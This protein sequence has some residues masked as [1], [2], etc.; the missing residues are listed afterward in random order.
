M[1]L[2]GKW[3]LQ[4]RIASYFGGCCL[5]RKPVHVLDHVCDES[6]CC[7]EAWQTKAEYVA[8]LM[9]VHTVEAL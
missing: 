7:V 9:V 4:R 1:N 2:Q 6:L 3:C 5:D 8:L